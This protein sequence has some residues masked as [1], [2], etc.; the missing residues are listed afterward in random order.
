M[1]ALDKLMNYSR[2]TKHI[3]S[4]V[5][6][7]KT[8]EGA[9]LERIHKAGYKLYD[10]NNNYTELYYV[11]TCKTNQV[12]SAIAGS[13][14]T[15]ALVFKI[16]YDIVTGFALDYTSINGGVPVPT[17][18]PMWVCT[19]L[20]TGA[21]E[22]ARKLYYWQ[23]KL[24]YNP[25]ATQISFSTLDAEFKRCINAMGVTTTIGD[26]NKL[27]S[28]LC[29]AIDSVGVTRQGN[30]LSKEDYHII[31]G[32]ITYHR[33]RLDTKRYSHPSC[34][35]YS[36][37]PKQIDLIVQQ[38]A[39]LRQSEGIMDFEEIMELL[40]KYLYV[41]PNENVQN[42]V[43]NR[44]NFIYVDEFQDTSQ[45]AYAILKFYGRGKLF[46]NKPECKDIDETGLQTGVVTRGTFSVVGD[47]SQ[48]IYSFR[49]S[50]SKILAERVHTDFKPK[51]NT[52]SVNWRCPSNILSPIV[53]SIH[54]NEDSATQVITSSADGGEF[55]PYSFPS[56]KTM[57]SQLSKDIE[58]DLDNDMSVAIACRTNFDGLIPAFVLAE[59][60]NFSFSISGE[61][62]TFD[63]PL[64]KKL[65]G[66]SSLFTEKVSTNVKNTLEL[67]SDRRDK[68][69]IKDLMN[70]LKTNRLS[71][72]DLPDEDLMYSYPSLYKIL[73]PIKSLFYKDNKRDKTLEVEAL[74]S[75]YIVII[76][77]VFNNDSAY[78]MSARSYIETL[79]YMISNYNFN[80]VYDFLE[81]I[82]R[83]S[84]K[85]KSSIKKST[86]DIHIS[87]VHELKG[88]EYD[89]VYV[90]ND[91]DG[92]Y[93]SSKCDK[94]ELEQLEEERR[95]HYI[96]CT[97]AKK[98]LHI[99]TLTSH[100]GMFTME[101]DCK[102][103]EPN[104]PMMTL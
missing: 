39:N 35:D 77:T 4:T 78:S 103:T 31:S 13:G 24:G 41:E 80:T 23:K 84:D 93:P 47:V 63:S 28:L 14:K 89:S 43:S 20:K 104:R 64:P 45:M 46:L 3:V 99:Y 90:W 67:L 62:M 57:L 55:Y 10:E 91:S 22:L 12:I 65:I 71:I 33:G 97:R 50:D 26:Q 29:K 79:L 96:A 75:L 40:Y 60:G 76:N 85:L 83:L 61:N 98:R 19:F 5:F 74:R 18:S 38:Y 21:E 92:V 82:D 59:H 7:T 81:E 25:T 17:V 27:F 56:I 34:K 66:V 73:N 1:N 53:S 54:K 95:V 9:L 11:L 58:D 36:L 6:D 49:G 100:R 87:T 70:T 68:W 72:W 94:T 88:K 16:I 32:I 48:C 2:S 42:F 69:R 44:Y 52:L 15:T 37:A 102:F 86:A 51:I 30:V 101:M 8:P